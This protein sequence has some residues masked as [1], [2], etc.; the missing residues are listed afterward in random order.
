MIIY[1]IPLARDARDACALRDATIPEN[2]TPN[3]SGALADRRP[4]LCSVLHRMG[5]FVPRPLLAER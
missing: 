2:E 1:L 3:F 4:F 5:F